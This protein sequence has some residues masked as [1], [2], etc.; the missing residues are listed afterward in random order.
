MKLI[1]VLFLCLSAVYADDISKTFQQIAQDY[2]YP[3]E[4]HFITTSDGYILRLF[5]IAH[6]KNQESSNNN[7]PILIQHGI[8]DSAD[9]VVSHGEDKSPAFNL[10]DQGY[11]V[12][13]A[14][15]RGNKYSRQHQTL[16]PDKDS[17]F[18]QFSFFEMIQDYKA[19]IEFVL[20]TTGAQKIPIIGHSQGTSSMLTGL[21]LE[22]SWFSDRV[23]LF[24]SLGTVTRL[25]H[26][27]SPL[28]KIL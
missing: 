6:G 5:R 26:M 22:S 12:W 13:V 4:Q 21:S 11:D 2:G 19:N 24:I 28:L 7:S 23:T 9:F 8:F 17:E 18:W 20:Q 15:S 3:F 14:N 25:D 1:V 10:A 16:N 27:T